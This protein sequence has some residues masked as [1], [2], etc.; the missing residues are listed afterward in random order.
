MLY[1]PY[2]AKLGISVHPHTQITNIGKSVRFICK[3]TSYVDWHFQGQSL[4][5]N[6]RTGSILL[7]NIH[8][9]TIINVKMDNTGMYTCSGEINFVTYESHGDLIVLCKSNCSYTVTS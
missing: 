4:P 2:V 5:S 8:W 9:L 6:T 7:R 3:F 1:I